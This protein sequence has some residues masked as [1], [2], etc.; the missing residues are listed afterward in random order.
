MATAEEDERMM[1][2]PEN[3]D[4]YQQQQR[5]AFLVGVNR[6]DDSNFKP[7]KFC[8]NDVQQLAKILTQLGYHVTC[9][10]DD[11]PDGKIPT[12]EA[13]EDALAVFCQ[14][15]GTQDLAFVHF[16]CHGDIDHHKA[17]DGVRHKHPVLI[18]QNTYK[19]SYAKRA[20]RVETLETQLRQMNAKDVFLSL[21]AC[22]VGVDIG[23]DASDPEFIQ[24][25]CQD[26]TGFMLL[27]GS[28]AQ[29]KAQEWGA[30][31]HGVY[32]YYL[33]Q[34]LAGE[35]GHAK[36]QAIVTA[37]GLQDYVLKNVKAWRL[38]HGYLPQEPT[39]KVEGTGD[40]MLACWH[41]IERLEPVIISADPPVTTRS[42]QS[43]LPPPIQPPPI[44]PP[45]AS[46]SIVRRQS[47]ERQ[48]QDKQKRLLSVEADLETANNQESRRS[49]EIRAEQLLTEIEDLEH[50]LKG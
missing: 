48:L 22:H 13:V 31:Q 30:V 29:Q 36:D 46:M 4:F 39:R 18:M 25:L 12:I 45:A 6:Y 37:S 9:F 47:Y 24:Y 27:A 41:G 17:A 19:N 16:A 1:A 7:L 15:V 14:T 8:V 35:A 2:I 42:P 3:Y 26:S 20:L 10:Y 40:M 11:H 5:W 43:S 49:L 44:Q 33:L 34:G 21:D 50:R 28:T 38:T 32:T 23:R